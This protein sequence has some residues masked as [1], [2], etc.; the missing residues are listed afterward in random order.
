MGY[1][2]KLQKKGGSKTRILNAEY[3]YGKSAP[4]TLSNTYTFLEKGIYF[5][6]LTCGYYTASNISFSTNNTVLYNQQINA[7]NGSTIRQRIIILNNSG[8]T[9][10]YS[11]PSSGESTANAFVCIFYIDYNITSVSVINTRAAID[12]TSSA[13]NIAI[14]NYGLLFQDTVCSSNPNVNEYYRLS[15]GTTDILDSRRAY[16]RGAGNNTGSFT[17]SLV[18]GGTFYQAAVNGG[19]Y[20]CTLCGAWNIS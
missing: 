7:S 14:A 15:S 19:G 11:I 16:W 9:C 1:A 10:T 17:L 20:G 12:S 3:V 13:T 5:M 4:G 6:C 18:H 2:V 8:N